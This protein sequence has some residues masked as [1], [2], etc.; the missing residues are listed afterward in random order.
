MG[1]VMSI[2][3]TAI[4]KIYHKTRTLPLSENYKHVK[5]DNKDS[6]VGKWY[7][8]RKGNWSD[9]TFA[10]TIGMVTRERGQ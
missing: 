2:E 10:K 3:R 8:P 1:E 4:V 9:L 6:P 7:S 5:N